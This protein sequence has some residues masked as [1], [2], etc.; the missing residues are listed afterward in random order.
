MGCWLRI[1]WTKR[2]IITTLQKFPFVT[3]KIDELPDRT[4][5]VSV[6]EAHS[7]QTGDAAA[8]RLYLARIRDEHALIVDAIG[9]ADPA[10]AHDAMRAHLKGS[11]ERYQNLADLAP[12]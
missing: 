11:Q 10:T 6:D 7:S 9:R 5:A 2:I 12:G 8:S 1:V 4:Y 3:E